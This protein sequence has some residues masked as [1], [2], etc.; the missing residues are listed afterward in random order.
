MTHSRSGVHEATLAPSEARARV[1]RL[2]EVR[3]HLG[4]RQDELAI[5]LGVSSWAIDSWVAGER[6]IPDTVMTDLRLL[7]QVGPD[8]RALLPLREF[9]TRAE[10]D[11]PTT[12]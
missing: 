2:H 1:M 3:R 11:T 7:E 4:L 12:R 9:D 5:Y 10:S 6:G 8:V